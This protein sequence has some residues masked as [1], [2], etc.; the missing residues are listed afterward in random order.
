MSV[1]GKW[2]QNVAKEDAEKMYECVIT[3]VVFKST[4]YEF[5][6][7]WVNEKDKTY[8]MLW[9]D[10]ERCMYVINPTILSLNL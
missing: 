3:D 10:V 9:P 5:E 1:P 8:I 2:W 7:I 4:R 6:I